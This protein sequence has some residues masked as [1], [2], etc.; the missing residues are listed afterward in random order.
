MLELYHH[1]SSVCAAKVRWGMVE[2]GL[3]FEAHYIDILKGE[4]FNPEYLK[5]NPKGVVPTLVHD[6]KV[7]LESTVI[8]EYLDLAFP[9]HKLTPVDPLEYVKTRKWTK[10]LD[11][12]LHSACGTLTFAS[13]HRHIVRKNL[14]EEELEEFLADTPSDS[15]TKDWAGRK[16]QIVAYGFEAP[17]VADMV[18][19][20]DDYL[21]QMDEDLRQTKWL[22]SSEF[23]LADISLT[24]YI[25]RI[26]MMGMS[27]WWENH[28][29][30]H[31]EKWWQQIQ[32][33]P[34]F[35]PSI[36]DWCPED[37]TN[38]L[39]SFGSQ[40][41]PDVRSILQTEDVDNG[42]AGDSDEAMQC[43]L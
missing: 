42:A 32:A 6:S 10:A 37:L 27:E 39:L 8:L 16:K 21:R 3:E 36:L 35:K 14:G 18:R 26:A 7:I 23:G 24:P 29:Y 1:G 30:P 13:A 2:K 33:L 4:Q 20:H 34:T 31:L 41:W 25:N 19:L 12:Y 43:R 40:S 5:L 28:R 17:G 22:A 11:E 38:D 15:V 9:E